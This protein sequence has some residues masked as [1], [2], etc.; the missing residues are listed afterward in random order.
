MKLKLFISIIAIV[1]VVTSCVSM[2]EYEALQQQYSQYSKNLNVARQEL[3]E[4]REENAELV[5]Q[6]QAMTV[7]LSDM[8]VANQECEATVA[9]INRSYAALQLRYDTTVENYMQQLTGKNRDLSKANKAL[10]ER[11]REIT[12]KEMAFKEKEERLLAQQRDLQERQQQA[13]Q[14]ERAI[15]EALES[16]QREL[17]QLKSSLTNALVGFKDK[18]LNVDTRDGKVYVS[19]ED[20][21]LFAS[22]SWAVSDQGAE[23]IKNLAAILE[24]NLDLSIMVEGHTDNDAYRGSSAIK[25]N[26]D[27]SVMRATSIVK[28]LLRLGPAIDP[29]RVVAAGHAE[30]SPKVKN[31]S[32]TNKAKNRRTEIILTPR[33]KEVM[34]LVE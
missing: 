25:D 8:T 33:L 7:A 18:G 31:S 9:S 14:N 22:G 20:K 26:W 34:K 23:A 13:L 29:A 15:G 27:L 24:R 4:L 32:A 11:N 5:R 12:A 1:P 3:K 19:M 17:E 21:L 28:L 2:K 30:Y 16:K 6:G 10:Q